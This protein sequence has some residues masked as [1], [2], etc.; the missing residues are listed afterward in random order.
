MTALRR[1]RLRQH[2]GTS[3][4]T[5]RPARPGR[6]TS[7]PGRT[8][9]AI[10]GGG[11]HT[12]AILDNGRVRCWGRGGSGQLGYGNTAEHRRQRDAGISR[13]GRPRRGTNGGGD[14]RRRIP[15]LRDPRQRQ[16]ALLGRGQAGPAR[17]RKHEGH[18]RQ[19]DARLGPARE[20][21]RGAK[22]RR[23]LRPA[24]GTPARSSTTARCAAGASASSGQLGYGNTRTI[25]DNE[26][27]ASVRPVKLGARRKAIAISASGQHSCAVL[28]NR[29]VRCWGT[30]QLRAAGLRQ[31]A[32]HRRQRAPRLRGPGE[33]RRGAKGRRDSGRR[34]SHLRPARQRPGALLGPRDRRPARLREHEEH[35]RQREAG[36]AG[37]VNLGGEV[38]TR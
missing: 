19:R 31:H 28:N 20:A 8:A 15:H 3:A 13:A 32:G 21:R 29:K 17:L 2:A 24:T 35:R 9:V 5:R 30:G 27:P 12:C 6:S 23:D 33:A 37:P 11:R 38:A 18:R 26:T 34:P 14:R 10:T 7:A 22:G 16:G 36:S 1:A 25:G 4:T